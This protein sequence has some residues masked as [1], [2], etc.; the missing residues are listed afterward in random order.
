MRGIF[1]GLHRIGQDILAGR[2]IESYVVTILALILAVAGVVDDAIPENWKMATILAALALL[3]FN[4]TRPDD[5]IVDLDAVLQDRDDF[6][7]FHDM[8]RDARELWIY[9]P[10]AINILRDVAY[11]KREILDRGGTV[12]VLTQ[13]ISN[14]EG[15]AF[16][17]DQ[18]DQT[19]DLENSLRMSMDILK[20][21]SRWGLVEYRVLPYCP[22]YSLVIVDPNHGS[23]GRM[24]LEVLGFRNDLV[25][26]R[27][28]MKIT[29]DQSQ[30]WF[31]HW[32]KQYEV[33]WDAGYPP[34]ENGQQG[35]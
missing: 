19:T 28:H 18:I 2:N 27:M 9:G 7:A 6:G 1:R 13:D 25:A 26:D 17:H 15:M 21:A 11:I 35:E 31:E 22:G 14:R 30:H 24:V 29:P 4:T 8:I 12:R 33:M 34:R 3:V 23:K 5:D 20:N 16:L 10:T 32:V